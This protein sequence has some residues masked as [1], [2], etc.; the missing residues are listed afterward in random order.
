MDTE[1]HPGGR[2]TVKARHL[3]SFTGPYGVVAAILATVLAI[4][5]GGIGY[6]I[7]QWHRPLAA[8]GAMTALLA[9]KLLLVTVFRAHRRRGFPGP[10]RSTRRP[11]MR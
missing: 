6:A 8:L 9:G 7:T 5:L 10:Q 3:H 4:H 11:G 2:F 1:R